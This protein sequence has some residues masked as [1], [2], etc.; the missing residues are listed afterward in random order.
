MSRFN[1]HLCVGADTVGEL[2]EK[3]ASE[4]Q[5]AGLLSDVPTEQHT[6][7]V[8]AA[9]PSPAPAPEPAAPPP[10]PG[11][12]ILRADLRALLGPLLATDKASEAKA[13]IK[14]HGSISNIPEDKLA[15][16]LELAKELAR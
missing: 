10:F 14:S 6:R 1:F 4:L 7:P 3:V 15:E 2:I 13:L 9:V 5:A 16:V 8:A 11:Y 12:E